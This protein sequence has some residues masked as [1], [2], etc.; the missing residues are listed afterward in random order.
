MVCDDKLDDYIVTHCGNLLYYITNDVYTFQRFD[1]M[2]DRIRNYP[3]EL[4]EINST[5][6]TI[7]IIAIKLKKRLAL[8]LLSEITEEFDIDVQDNNGW[9]ALMWACRYANESYSFDLIDMLLD[10][11]ADTD[12]INHQ[13]MSAMNI[14]V[15]YHKNTKN[16]NI[17][18]IAKMMMAHGAE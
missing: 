8:I 9:T 13:G 6:E 14:L 2:I 5:G 3:N 15:K 17:I 12:L 18:K 4:Y 7:L 1:L 16:L 11:G 10:K